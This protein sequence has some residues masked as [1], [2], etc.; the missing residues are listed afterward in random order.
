MR[1]KKKPNAA[2]ASESSIFR[3]PSI[4]NR[5]AIV[6]VTIKG[7][8]IY[9]K[10]AHPE[11]EKAGSESGMVSKKWNQSGRLCKAPYRSPEKMIFTA[12]AAENAE[13]KLKLNP[14]QIRILIWV[15]D[16]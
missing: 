14:K 12:K 7:K 10:V 2:K 3:A 4:I 9:V 6:A 15:L 16:I 11:E 5:F 1:N 8:K 13:M